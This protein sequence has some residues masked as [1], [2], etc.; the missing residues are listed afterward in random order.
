MVRPDDIKEINCGSGFG[1]E[2]ERDAILG[3]FTAWAMLRRKSG[4]IDLLKYEKEERIL[5]GDLP[6]GYWMPK[7]LILERTA[8]PGQP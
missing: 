8:I 5:A 2:D 7:N 3:S 4:W 6:I 1:S